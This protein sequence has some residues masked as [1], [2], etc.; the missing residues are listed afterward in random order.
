MKASTSVAEEANDIFPKMA[1]M[2][3]CKLGHGGSAD[4]K[5]TGLYPSP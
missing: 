3:A 4:T 1:K 2:P 5:G